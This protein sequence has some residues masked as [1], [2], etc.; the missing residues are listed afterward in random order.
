MRSPYEKLAGMQIFGDDA[1][2]MANTARDYSGDFDFIDI[3]MGCPAPKIVRNNQGSALMK[4][5]DKSYNIVKT[6]VDTLDKP[7]T[8][9]IRTG[10]DANSINAVEFAKAMEEAGAS[11]LTIHGRHRSQ[12]YSGKADLSIIKDVVDAL[13]IPVVGNGDIYTVEDAIKNERSNWL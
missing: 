10:W 1:D 11:L 4:D 13:N 5:I 6:M 2:I 9:K 8:V 12:Y 7:V 3:N